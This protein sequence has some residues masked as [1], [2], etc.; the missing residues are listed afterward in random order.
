M[1]AG[2]E[3]SARIDVTHQISYYKGMEMA[4]ATSVELQ[5]AKNLRANLRRIFSSGR[6]QTEV[7][8]D[9]G[10]NRVHLAKIL[11]GATPNP[12]LDSVEA[13]AIALEIPM[14]TLIS[15]D[16]SDTDLRIFRNSDKGPLDA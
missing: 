5:K 4:T 11:N 3:T 1:N 10:M 12:T 7:A 8:K 9:A 16:P 13:I 2:R 14:E 15:R 6:S